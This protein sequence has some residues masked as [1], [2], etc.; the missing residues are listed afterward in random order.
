MSMT[1]KDFQRFAE[2]FASGIVRLQRDLTP[3]RSMELN[4][5][6]GSYER[7][8]SDFITVCKVLNPRFDEGRF[9]AAIEREKDAE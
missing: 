8:V 4:N 7:A 6:L 1:R 9:R 5:C 3:C 2:E